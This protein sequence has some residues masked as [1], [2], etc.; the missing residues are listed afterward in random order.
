MGVAVA[1]LIFRAIDGRLEPWEPRA[2]PEPWVQM[3]TRRER[4]WYARHGHRGRRGAARLA[5]PAQRSA[6]PMPEFCAIRRERHGI[7]FAGFAILEPYE[8]VVLRG[9]VYAMPV[10]YPCPYGARGPECSERCW[11]DRMH[12]ERVEA[13]VYCED[14]ERYEAEIE[15][16]LQREVSKVLERERRMAG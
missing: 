1:V 2:C 3:L 6:D 10:A 16:V 7:P 5:A 12:T 4:R 11:R 9:H 8:E 13:I 14:P 15:R